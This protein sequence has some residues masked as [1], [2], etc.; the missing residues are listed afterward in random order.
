MEKIK[1][2]LNNVTIKN[3]PTYM[4]GGIEIWL[5]V[6]EDSI[7]AFGAADNVE[8]VL[9]LLK[10]KKYVEVELSEDKVSKKG[11]TYKTFTSIKE[12][13]NTGTDEAKS[14]SSSL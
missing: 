2:K 7:K 13:K 9:E 1:G 10:T 5:G 6:G 14:F 8:E 12:Q 3:Y 11:N 4:V